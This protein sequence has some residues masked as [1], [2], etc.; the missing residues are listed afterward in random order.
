M[1]SI[2]SEVDLVLKATEVVEST[3]VDADGNIVE[4]IRDTVTGGKRRRKRGAKKA[5]GKKKGA[6]KH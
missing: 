3:E 2:H 1:S 6:K 4:V 5:G